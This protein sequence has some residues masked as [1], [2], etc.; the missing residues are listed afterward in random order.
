MFFRFP[1]SYLAGEPREYLNWGYA[2][3]ILITGCAWYH[4][5]VLSRII[6]MVEAILLPIAASGSVN[7]FII[8]MINW[9]VAGLWLIIMLIERSRYF[10]FFETKMQKHTIQWLNMH[11]LIITWIL[12][13]HIAFVFLTSRAP[14]KPICWL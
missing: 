11:L 9:A 4:K 7:T 10:H 14:K 13:A 12:I 3:T 2:M 6:L 5:S 1:R 8:S